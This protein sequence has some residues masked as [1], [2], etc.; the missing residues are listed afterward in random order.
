LY[1]LLLRSSLAECYTDTIVCWLESYCFDGLLAEQFPGWNVCGFA[2]LLAAE[3]VC[4]FGMCLVPFR[5][6]FP[7]FKF[8]S[9]SLEISQEYLY[10]IAS[11]RTASFFQP[12]L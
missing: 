6:I 9:I 3:M 8:S 11:Y 7:F 10:H 2:S 5:G 4:G 12:Q 1:G